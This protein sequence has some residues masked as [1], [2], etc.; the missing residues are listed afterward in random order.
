MVI[1]QTLQDKI[2]RRQNMSLFTKEKKERITNKISTLLT[3][4][5]RIYCT[6]IVYRR[7]TKRLNTVCI[8][9]ILYFM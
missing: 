7:K 4:F 1:A 8:R 5:L 3:K 6:H 2:T 9:N